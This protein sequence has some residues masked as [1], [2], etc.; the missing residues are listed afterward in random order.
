MK[1]RSAL[2]LAA[3]LMTQ[4]VY[5]IEFVSDFESE[6]ADQSI[7]TEYADD[8]AVGITDE[9]K[10]GFTEEIFISDDDYFNS[11]DA[12]DIDSN[13]YESDF[14][15]AVYSAEKEN[16]GF[17]IPPSSL[18]YRALLLQYRS[19]VCLKPCGMSH[20]VHEVQPRS[21]RP[22]EFRLR[23]KACPLSYIPV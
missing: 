7:L 1:K 10:N 12:R 2:F 23:A 13:V 19:S 9:A 11:E 3:V 20:A 8:S 21:L 22:P 5:G 16:S 4:N 6:P 18:Q 17:S 15:S 14:G